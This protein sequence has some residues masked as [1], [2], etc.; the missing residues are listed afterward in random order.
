[1]QETIDAFPNTPGVYLFKDKKGAVLYVGKAKDLKKRVKSYFLGQDERASVV[2]LVKRTCSLDYIMTDSEKEALLLENTLIKK[3]RPRYNIHLK[4]DKTYIS[5][6]MN[7]QHEAP[8]VFVT[9]RVVKDGSFYFGPYVSSQAAREAVEQITRFF[10]IRTCKD[11]E[12]ANRVRPCLKYDIGRCTAPCVKYVSLQHYAEQ[13][14]EASLFL[15]GRSKKLLHVLEEKMKRASEEMDYELAARY[16]DAL[17]LLDDVQEKQK[18]VAQHGESFDAI[19]FA[20][21]EGFFVLCVMMIRK[22]ILLDTAIFQLGETS[23]NA[24]EVVH[25][26]LLQRYLGNTEMPPEIYLPL[27]GEDA[28]NIQ[29]ILIAKRKQNVKLLV[30]QRGLKKSF[31]ELAEKNAQ[32]QLPQ[33]M[34]EEKSFEEVL[35]QLQQKLHLSDLPETIECVDISHLQGKDAYGSLVCFRRGKPAKEAYRLFTIKSLSTPD[36]YAMMYE[37]LMRRFGSFQLERGE[38]NIHLPPPDL[39]L[40]D[41]GK[42]QLA[43]AMRVLEELGLSSLPVCALAKGSEEDRGNRA[44]GKMDDRVFVPGRKNHLTFKRGSKELLYLMRIRDEAHRFGITAHRKKRQKI[45]RN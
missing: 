19:G 36:D 11:N 20:N 13:V 8:G 5:I 21:D 27:L 12:Y 39:L 29:D 33:K 40:V 26:F 34:K 43:I 17:R 37:V 38:K 23:S 25:T 44:K 28:E 10:R 1:M 30:P 7:V 31:I 22:G 24:E 15:K 18:V 45:F 16:R 3:Y 35:F 9:R 14:E 32:Q 6:R 42:G 2:F 41:G 4:D